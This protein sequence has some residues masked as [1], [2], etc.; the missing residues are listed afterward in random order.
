MDLNELKNVWDSVDER[1]KKQEILRESIIG[2]MIYKKTSK[3]LNKLV[4]SEFIAIAVCLGI[5]PFI[6]WAYGKFGG[7]FLTWDILILYSLLFDIVVLPY[8]LYKAYILIKIDLIG[9]M[10]SNSYYINKFEIAIKREKI[11]MTILGPIFIIIMIPMLIEL[12]ANAFAWAFAICMV[13]FASLF[14]YWSYKKIYDKNIKSI[15]KSLEEL[16][17]LEDE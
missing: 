5:I 9:N 14:T 13:I 7:R 4:W 3:S 16:K 11:F 17:E 12:R 15:K 10:K 2:E 8:I 6:V 1:L